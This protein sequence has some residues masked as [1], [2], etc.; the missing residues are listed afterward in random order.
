LLDIVEELFFLIG[1]KWASVGKLADG[2]TGVGH[3]RLDEWRGVGGAEKVLR[4]QVSGKAAGSWKG[5]SER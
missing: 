3:G 2:V 4:W 1:G 5:D